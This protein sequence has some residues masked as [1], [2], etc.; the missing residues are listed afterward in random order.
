MD[1]AAMAKIAA[2]A[3]PMP[4]TK[5]PDPT[6]GLVAHV[7][8]DY[9]A[10]YCAGN[11]DTDPGTARRNFLA[12]LDTIKRASGATE[13]VVH[14]TDHASTKG[15]RYLIA[16]VKQYQGQRDSSRKPKNWD[17]LREYIESYEGTAFRTKNWLTRE[18]DDG[19]AY[20]AHAAAKAGKLC[21]I[22]TRDKDMRMLPGRHVIWETTQLVEV[23]YGAFEVTGA[24]GE[25]YGHKWFWLQMLQ[26]DAADFIPGLP[27]YIT[28]K[29]KVGKM[30]PATAEKFLA[31]CG[32]NTD[33]FRVVKEL[34]KTY[35]SH[36]DV[37][38]N[39][40]AHRFVEQAALLWL[41]T[42]TDAKASDFMQIVPH[43]PVV[44][45]AVIDMLDY[46]DTKKKELEALKQ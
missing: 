43:D 4:F 8:G 45:Y 26:G 42:D 41:R 14:I 39:N 11:D 13:V 3:R 24:D 18:A 25:T 40:W 5:V 38:Y 22:A 17:V 21:V 23:P 34:Y 7:D 37:T 12:R 16:T 1:V 36:A 32:N 35:Y 10:Y 2:A 9:C 33:A 30:G 20:V 15:D 44:N 31:G 6:P 29:D 46:V 27:G 28:P 19:M